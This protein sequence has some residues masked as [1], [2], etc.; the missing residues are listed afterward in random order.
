MCVRFCSRLVCG[1]FYDAALANELAVLFHDELRVYSFASG[2]CVGF[3]LLRSP[4]EFVVCFI[5]CCV[6]TVLPRVR[7]WGYSAQLKD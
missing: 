4:N 6:C 3:S 1:F 7:V 2:R 5:T